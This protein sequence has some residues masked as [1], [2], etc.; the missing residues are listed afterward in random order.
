MFVSCFLLSWYLDHAKWLVK[1]TRYYLVTHVFWLLWKVWMCRCITGNV[2][3]LEMFRITCFCMSAC[4]CIPIH[5]QL[6]SLSLLRWS[7]CIKHRSLRKK[8]WSRSWWRRLRHPL[9]RCVHGYMHAWS[10]HFEHLP[11]GQLSVHSSPVSS[12]YFCWRYHQLLL[13]MQ[14]FK[15]TTYQQLKVCFFGSVHVCKGLCIGLCTNILPCKYLWWCTCVCIHVLFQ[16][17]DI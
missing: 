5:M 16:S 1:H 14:P 6:P 10:S 13:V 11:S 4:T 9:S 17:V 2:Q 12:I 3:F 8:N 7:S 15:R